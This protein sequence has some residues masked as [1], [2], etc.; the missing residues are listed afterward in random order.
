VPP[1]GELDETGAYATFGH[2]DFFTCA[3]LC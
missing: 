2:A 1:P 3:T